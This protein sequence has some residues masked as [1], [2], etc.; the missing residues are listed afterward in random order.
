[1]NIDQ[2]HYSLLNLPSTEKATTAQPKKK[3]EKE[4]EDKFLSHFSSFLTV[5]LLFICRFVA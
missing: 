3:K 5:Y 2:T 4:K 1:M